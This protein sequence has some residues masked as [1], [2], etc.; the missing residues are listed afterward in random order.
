MMKLFG[1]RLGV[2]FGAVALLVCGYAGWVAAQEIELPPTYGS[3]QLKSGF[4]EDP[5][6]VK[7]TAGGPIKTNKGGVFA[8]IAKAPDFKLYYEAGQFPLTIHVDS[9]ADTTLLINLPDGTWVANDDQAEGNL[10]PLVR[11]AKPQSG[12]YDIYVGTVGPE[13]AQ[14]TL[15]VT[16]LK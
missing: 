2:G 1:W 9:K 16:E 14:A 13:P 7:L 15:Y 10:N 11:F 6:T 3:L 8:H 4:A 5:R 12:R